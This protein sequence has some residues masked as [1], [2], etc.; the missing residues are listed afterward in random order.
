MYHEYRRDLSLIYAKN[1]LQVPNPVYVDMTSI[2]SNNVNYIYQI[3]VAGGFY[4]KKESQY[5]DVVKANF[6]PAITQVDNFKKALDL[7]LEA[8]KYVST[9]LG[10]LPSANTGDILMAVKDGYSS[11][12]FIE[13]FNYSNLYYSQMPNI[14]RQASIR[15]AD[16]YSLFLL[17]DY[18]GK[19]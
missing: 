19:Y 7:E 16:E 17:P 18:I 4:S 3:L 13:L 9:N 15:E 11:F 8:I 10:N 14:F 5:L 2:S 1:Y 6:Y 12:Y